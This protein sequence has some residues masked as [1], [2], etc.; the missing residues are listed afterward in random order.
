LET[1]GSGV[2]SVS[3]AIKTGL[4]KPKPTPAMTFAITKP[5]NAKDNDATIIPIPKIDKP[6][7][8][9]RKRPIISDNAPENS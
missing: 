7:R 8:I 3:K 5:L 9:T 2:I 4:T 1:L 6:K